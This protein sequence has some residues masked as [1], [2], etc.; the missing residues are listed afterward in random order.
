MQAVILAAGKG[1]RI[2]PFSLEKPKPLIPVANKPVL[3][4]NLDQMIGLI[5]EAIIVVGYK[6]DMIIDHFGHYYKGIKLTYLIQEEQKGTGH[7]LMIAEKYVKEKCIVM[8]GDD[9]FSRKDIINL[10]HHDNCLLVQYKEDPSA[11]GAVV[12][13]N[14][15]VKEIVEKSPILISHYVNTGLYCFNPDVFTILHSITPSIRG[16]YEL[17]DAVKKLADQKKMAA[18]IVQGFWI[19]VGYPWHILDATEILLEHSQTISIKGRLGQNVRLSGT[20]DI[21]E[22]SSLQDNCVVSGNII[23]GKNTQLGHN[24]KVSGFTAIGDHCIIA[25]NVRLH[26]MVIGSGTVI[27]ENCSLADSVL[28]EEVTIDANV[29]ITNTKSIPADHLTIEVSIN[30]KTFDSGK[31]KLGAFVSDHSKIHHDLHPGE[32]INGVKQK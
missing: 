20:A 12:I 24:V 8:N 10:A 19:P 28:G 31:E 14:N 17:T 4:H 30:G 29:T 18:E 13:E 23:I 15:S 9:L 1:T 27:G 11:F 6:K 22:N 3:E 7:A 16:E 32:I 2:Y 5:T 21:G 26:N 25:D